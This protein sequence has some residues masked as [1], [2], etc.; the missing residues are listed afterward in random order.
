MCGREVVRH[1]LLSEQEKGS[2]R[3]AP[4]NPRAGLRLASCS[5]YEGCQVRESRFAFGF[6]ARNLTRPR[7]L[8]CSADK[9]QT[10]HGE[11]K[12]RGAAGDPA[13]D[14][15]RKRLRYPVLFVAAIVLGGVWVAGNKLRRSASPPE[16]AASTLDASTAAAPD[17]SG[18]S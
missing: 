11:P 3:N 14:R 12:S 15:G 7:R 5:A 18:S 8:L 17:R 13:G 9:M 1:Q 4:S 6:G 10:N 16:T 2:P